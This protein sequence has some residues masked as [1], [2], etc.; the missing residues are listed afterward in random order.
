MQKTVLSFGE[1]LWDLFPSGPVLGGAPLN[2]ASRVNSLGDRGIIVTRLGRDDHGRKALAQIVGSGMDRSHIQKD[3]HHPT[4]T[5]N[6]TLDNKGNPEFFIVPE[7]AYDFIEV[8]YES[9]ELAGEADCFCF[10][11]LAQRTPT[12]RLTLRRLLDVAAKSVKFLDVNLRKDCFSRETVVESLKR[13]DILKMNLEEAHYLAELLE[14][15]LSSLPDF[16]AAMMEEWSLRGCV[17]TLGEHGALAASADGEKIYV[18]GY[19]IRVADTC[20][21]GDAFS[22]GFIHEYL[23]GEPL[24]GCC[25]LGNA[26]GAM[27]AM[28]TGA[29]TPLSLDEVRHFLNANRRRLAEPGLNEF[30]A[31]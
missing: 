28:Q 21:A 3:D 16:C 9:M 20:G 8:T 19:E 26:L 2:L 23:R 13:A 4:G 24:A 27:V 18:P 5:V 7:V 29:T 22:A 11:T 31:E 17:V 6:V 14:I 15:S 30:A 10:G 25:G 12:S 1:T